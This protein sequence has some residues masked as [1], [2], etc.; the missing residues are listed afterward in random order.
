LVF[1]FVFVSGSVFFGRRMVSDFRGCDMTEAA[2][3]AAA[4][5]NKYKRRW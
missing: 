1:V 2:A 4:S 3:A 5:W